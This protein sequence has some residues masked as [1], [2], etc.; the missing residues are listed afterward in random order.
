MFIALFLSVV[1]LNFKKNPRKE[2]EMSTKLHLI[3]TKNGCITWKL[4]DSNSNTNMCGTPM[5]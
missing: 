5:N 1:S 2:K 3:D 4:D